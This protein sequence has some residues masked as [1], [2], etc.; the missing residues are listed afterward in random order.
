MTAILALGAASAQVV[1]QTT[2]TTSVTT[3][4]GTLNTFV[5]G[6][7]FV[8]KEQSGPVSYTYG[9]DVTYVTRGGVVLTPD[10]VRTR[11]RAGLPVHVEYMPQG[12]T[13]VIKRVVINE[14]HDDDDDDD[15]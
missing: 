1:E 4:D 11:V 15:D 7:A 10:Q 14:E 2:T 9:P 3:A 13:R 12:E 6:S 5:P 8:V